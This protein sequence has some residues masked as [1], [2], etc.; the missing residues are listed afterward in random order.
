V[1]VYAASQF[2]LLIGDPA[3]AL[4]WGLPALILV[5]AAAGV[6]ATR[7]LRATNP[8]L[9]ALMGRSRGDV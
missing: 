1:A 4:S 8:Q 3:S 7:V 5:A 9:W 6:L 2:G